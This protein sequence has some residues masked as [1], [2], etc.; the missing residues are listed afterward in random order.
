MSTVNNYELIEG[1]ELDL[2]HPPRGVELER[3]ADLLVECDNA[4]RCC[5]TPKEAF[6]TVF[7]CRAEQLLGFRKGYVGAIDVVEDTVELAYLINSKEWER[8]G[9][10][11]TIENYVGSGRP[12]LTAQ[13]KLMKKI[14]MD[15]E[16]YIT[17]DYKLDINVNPKLRESI[18]LKTVI[19]SPFVVFKEVVGY[20]LLGY[21]AY[22]P[23]EVQW[24]H[25]R[26][27][28]HT[29]MP[30][31]QSSWVAKFRAEVERA[32]KWKILGQQ[33]GALAHD[34]KTPIAILGGSLSLLESQTKPDSQ[35]KH[36][37]EGAK[38]QVDRL[39]STIANLL[40]FVREIDLRIRPIKVRLLIQEAIDGSKPQASQALLKGNA[41]DKL[42]YVDRDKIALVLRNIIDNAYESPSLPNCPTRVV[43]IKADGDEHEVRISVVDN[44]PGIPAESLQ[45]IF[46]PFYSTKREGHGLGLAVSKRFVSEHGG[47]IHATNSPKGGASFEIV[48]PWRPIKGGKR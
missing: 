26:L 33:A 18:K 24:M 9:D 2:S 37:I 4:I 20:V 15:M 19:V 32:T 27:V 35:G 39:S 21:S 48:L 38:Y 31:M 13:G 46:D 6:K 36:L 23:A 5:S 40:S 12:T 1:T 29:A 42:L 22:P 3:F 16:P 14:L 44:G 28:A 34:L 47:R 41:L 8:D 10:K 30:I 45:R 25:E 7:G 43:E 11:D 17:R